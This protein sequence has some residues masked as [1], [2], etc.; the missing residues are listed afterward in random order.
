MKYLMSH[1]YLKRRIPKSTGREMFG[2]DY[3]EAIA[4]KFEMAKKDWM[5][6]ATEFTARTIHDQYERFI[7]P[8]VL[9]NEMIVSG[10]GVKNLFLMERLKFYFHNVKVLPSSDFGIP[11]GAKEAMLFALLANEAVLGHPANL[12]RV[13]GANK[14]TVL[15]KISLP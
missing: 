3:C 8:H 9:L 13:T 6:T 1:E 15:G 11:A 12:P 14:K 7:K 10:G 2:E 4:G 5:A